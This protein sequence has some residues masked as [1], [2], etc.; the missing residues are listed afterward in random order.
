VEVGTGVALGTGEAVGRPL[1][2]D[3]GI[4]V[5]VGTGVAEAAP[6]GVGDGVCVG[7]TGG[8]EVPLQPIG[9]KQRSAAATIIKRQ[10]ITKELQSRFSAAKAN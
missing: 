8:D 4:A 9:T 2:V 1:A 6:L 3:V 10:T 7:V 5:G